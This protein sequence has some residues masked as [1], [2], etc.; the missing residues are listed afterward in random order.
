MTT[1]VSRK[2][3]KAFID[4]FCLFSDTYILN[5]SNPEWKLFFGKHEHPP[6][7]NKRGQVTVFLITIGLQSFSFAFAKFS[8]LSDIALHSQSS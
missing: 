5:K 4:K 3:V 2:N 1:S 7:T 6:N 8:C